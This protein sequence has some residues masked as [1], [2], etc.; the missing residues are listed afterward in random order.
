[1]S[2]D[3]EGTKL[4]KK[5]KSIFKICFSA[6]V[7]AALAV[8]S[9]ATCGAAAAIFTGAAI[10]AGVGLAMGTVNGVIEGKESGDYLGSIADNMV[11]NTISG[12]ISGAL[13]ASPVGI[14]G[15]IVCNALISGGTYLI[16]NAVNGRESNLMDFAISTGFGALAGSLAGKGYLAGRTELPIAPIANC[17]WPLCNSLLKGTVSTI[18]GNV[19]GGFV[20]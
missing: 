19:V 2:V 5:G 8:A 15:Q 20:G 7:V 4:S 17:F 1:M 9:V 10:G 12:A 6:L 11:T 16:S 3:T 13:A 14:A 18:A